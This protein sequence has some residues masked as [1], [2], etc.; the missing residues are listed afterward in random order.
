[1]WLAVEQTYQRTIVADGSN[2]AS[3]LK[4]LAALRGLPIVL[5]LMDLDDSFVVSASDI[6]G[7]FL[8]PLLAASARYGADAMV[9]ARVYPDRKQTASD[10]QFYDISDAKKRFQ[11][12]GR[13]SGNDDELNQALINSTTDWLASR[14]AVTATALDTDKLTIIVENISDISVY[15]QLEKLL[16]SL[17]SVSKAKLVRQQDHQTYFSLRLVGSAED[18][19]NE[20][21]LVKNL[22]VVTEAPAEPDQPER[23]EPARSDDPQPT[24]YTQQTDDIQATDDEAAAP[25]LPAEVAPVYHRYRWVR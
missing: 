22:K 10:W 14:Y 18:V 19:L 12:G 2:Q 5:P 7:G 16:D 24:D 8:D 6:W 25:D 17:V 11:Q 23:M 21:D 1:V 20:L 15:L 9:V 3:Q 13:I 4:E